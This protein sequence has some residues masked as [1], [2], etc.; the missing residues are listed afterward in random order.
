MPEPS[1]C[2]DFGGF[3]CLQICSEV[4]SFLSVEGEGGMLP[5]CNV[6][7]LGSCILQTEQGVQSFVLQIIA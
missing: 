4:G 2:A 3:R 7:V 5:C 6:T 1:S